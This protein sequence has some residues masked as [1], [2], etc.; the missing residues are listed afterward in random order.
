MTKRKKAIN[1]HRMNTRSRT[2]AGGNGSNNNGDDAVSNPTA[3]SGQANITMT[4]HGPPAAP[5]MKQGG[6]WKKKKADPATKLNRF[7][8]LDR[9]QKINLALK[10]QQIAALTDDQVQMKFHPSFRGNGCIPAPAALVGRLELEEWRFAHNQRWKEMKPRERVRMQQQVLREIE[11][12]PSDSGALTGKRIPSSGSMGR[13]GIHPPEGLS[14]AERSAWREAHNERWRT[15]SERE[16]CEMKLEQMSNSAATTTQ[17]GPGPMLQVSQ[18]QA[19]A[20][21]GRDHVSR[22]D[23]LNHGREVDIVR[24]QEAPM[25]AAVQEDIDSVRTSR[26]RARSPE[27]SDASSDSF[28]YDA[29]EFISDKE[30]GTIQPN[31]KRVRFNGPEPTAAAG[32]YLAQRGESQEATAA[33]EEN[34]A[35]RSDGPDPG[36]VAQESLTSGLEVLDLAE[37]SLAPRVFVT[38]NPNVKQPF[39]RVVTIDS[40]DE[41]TQKMNDGNDTPVSYFD[42]GP[43]FQLSDLHI[44]EILLRRPSFFQSIVQI[45]AGSPEIRLPLTD[46]GLVRLVSAC[47]ILENLS[48]HGGIYLSDRSIAAVIAKCKYI[49]HLALCGADFEPNLVYGAALHQLVGLPVATDLDKIALKNTRVNEVMVKR[50]RDGRPGLKITYSG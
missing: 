10:S 4:H 7:K 17:A 6:R 35:T 13:G 40:Q 43:H 46:I 30:S 44:H 18:F 45:T 50:L 29:E 20:V 22:N 38:P 31:R 2:A 34:H 28:Y 48:I 16:R 25:A 11:G 32:E 9:Q 1:T 39:V 8:N 23:A 49:R 37:E 12:R 19:Q 24:E 33:N 3:P 21:Q 42:F 5:R 36:E 26:K 15:M 27:G 41:F 47:P 14:F